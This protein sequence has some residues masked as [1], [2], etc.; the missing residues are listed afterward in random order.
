MDAHLAR[1][2]NRAYLLAR[3]GTPASER[4][5][6]RYMS[7]SAV[8]AATHCA[9]NP[10]KRP[11]EVVG[12]H[13][14]PLRR[15]RDDATIFPAGLGRDVLC[16]RE[17]GDGRPVRSG[18][19]RASGSKLCSF[20]RQSN[21][22]T[23]NGNVPDP[24]SAF[25]EV[26]CHRLHRHG[27]HKVIIT[28]HTL[29]A[30]HLGRGAREWSTFSRGR[31]IT[32]SASAVNEPHYF[33]VPLVHAASTDSP[34][35]PTAV[36]ARVL[37]SQVAGNSTESQ[38]HMDCKEIL[39]SIPNRST[40]VEQRITEYSVHV[41]VHGADPRSPLGRGFLQRA[42]PD[43]SRDGVGL[44]HREPRSPK[45]SSPRLL[46]TCSH[47]HGGQGGRSTQHRGN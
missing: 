43:A 8:A 45:S 30:R 41:H 29:M 11:Q 24:H 9:Q 40:P 2:Q 37:R 13:C 39:L 17:T 27:A 42:G 25:Y 38:E 36:Q 22:T 10:T 19:K 35:R 1:A 12:D 32:I 6:P 47:R 3:D 5:F 18:V 7:S 15:G 16:E 33:H 28:S 14:P 26:L 20:D 34:R 23:R 46:I 31:P 21:W 4:V 44:A